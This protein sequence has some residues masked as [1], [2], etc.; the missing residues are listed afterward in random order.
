M[1]I[2][3]TKT[4]LHPP[5]SLMGR[6]STTLSLFCYM[7]TRMEVVGL[8]VCVCVCV[9]A[10]VCGSAHPCEHACVPRCAYIHLYVHVSVCVLVC[11][12]VHV[13]MFH[14]LYPSSRNIT[15]MVGYIT[16]HLNLLNILF[17]MMDCDKREKERRGGGTRVRWT[18]R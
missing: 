13:L 6:T 14:I 2:F 9:R 11:I 7:L 16:F 1:C 5:D 12:S 17:M 3:F 8:C 15:S 4:E 18:C 10:C